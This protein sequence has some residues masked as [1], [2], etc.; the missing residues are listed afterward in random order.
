[1]YQ[2]FAARTLST[3]IGF[4][5]DDDWFEPASQPL[6]LMTDQDTELFAKTAL[7]CSPIVLLDD[8]APVIPFGTYDLVYEFNTAI[9][10][11]EGAVELDAMPVDSNRGAF[12]GPL[13]SNMGT[14]SRLSAAYRRPGVGDDLHRQ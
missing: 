5:I 12:D 1:M 7:V 2:G 14:A 6:S 8:G 4:E 9:C 11:K 3:Q 13:I 10:K